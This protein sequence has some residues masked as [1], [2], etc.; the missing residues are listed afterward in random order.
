MSNEQYFVKYSLV[1][2]LLSSHT[3]PKNRQSLLASRC[4]SF[5][6][7]SFVLNEHIKQKRFEFDTF[8]RTLTHPNVEPNHVM[9]S[10]KSA[11]IK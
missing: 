10:Q 3:L 1:L 4:S 7:V 5:P 11:S 8:T 2:S 9:S 6:L